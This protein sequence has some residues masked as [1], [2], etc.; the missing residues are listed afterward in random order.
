[1]NALIHQYVELVEHVLIQM[2]LIHVHV[3]MVIQGVVMLLHALVGLYFNA[4]CDVIS[5]NVPPPQEL[6]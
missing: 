5:A 3:M 1:M 2:V 6:I 4:I